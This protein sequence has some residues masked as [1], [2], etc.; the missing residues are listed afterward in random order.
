MTRRFPLVREGAG[1]LI[2]LKAQVVPQVTA[3]FQ[4]AD[5]AAFPFRR[6]RPTHEIHLRS[7]AA[8]GSCPVVPKPHGLNNNSS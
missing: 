5:E 6:S 8:E 3:E 7:R 1:G 2:S 4:R